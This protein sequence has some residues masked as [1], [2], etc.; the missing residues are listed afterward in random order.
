MKKNNLVL[1]FRLAILTV[2]TLAVLMPV[3]SVIHEM[4]HGAMCNYYGNDFAWSLNPLGGGWLSCL[5]TIDDPTMFR[6]AGGLVAALIA[7]IIFILVLPH[8][9][10][11]TRFIGITL[12][13]IAVTEYAIALLEVFA[14]EFYMN[15]PYSSGVSATITAVIIIWLVLRH[16]KK[17]EMR[18]I[19]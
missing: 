2:I 12:A 9:G 18:Q 17:T 4:G 1:D 14:N 11:N 3:F 16:S 19:A 15:S 13:S 7:S 6:L 10:E 5:G 8:L